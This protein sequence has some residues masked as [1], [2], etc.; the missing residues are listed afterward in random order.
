M[1]MQVLTSLELRQVIQDFQTVFL[2]LI[3]HSSFS[4][5]LRHR[6]LVKEQ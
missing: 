5:L 1:G 6:G 3:S 2:F 4:H